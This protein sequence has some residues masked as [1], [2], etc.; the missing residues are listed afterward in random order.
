LVHFL[1]IGAVVY[2]LYEWF[3]EPVTEE[4]QNTIVISAGDIEWLQTT[5]EK[6][7]NRPPTPEE[8]DGMIQAHIKETVLYREALSM[9]LDKNDTVIRRRLGQKL[10]FL[11]QD[12]ANLNPPSDDELRA[13]FTANT[14]RYQEPAVITVTQVFIDPDKRGEKTLKDARQ[15]LA[16]LNKR[17]PPTEDIEDVGD[18]LML[19]RY[20]PQRSES[21][22]AKLFGDEF[23]QEIFGL[24]PGQ[25]HGP[26]ESGYGV[27]LVY[28]HA[29]REPPP[30][31][32]ED[33][34][35]RVRQ[36]WEDAKR[37]ELNERYY[38]GLLTRYEVIVEGEPAAQAKENGAR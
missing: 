32:Y 37:R 8:L 26:V 15:I 18:R 36:D 4:A 38:A 14:E 34:Q 27:H 3:T 7:W 16:Q 28:V 30:P 1:L 10:E 12:L 25:W 21:E 33:V 13:Y 29:R 35:E 24:A 19:Q 5:W 9:G 20:Y 22:M 6:R 31:A 11:C 23:A 2:L 17:G